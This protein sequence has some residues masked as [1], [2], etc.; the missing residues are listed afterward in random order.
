MTEKLL[1]KKEVA[2]LIGCSVH[3]LRADRRK[4]TG[5]RYVKIDRRIRYKP[6]DVDAYIERRIVETSTGKKR[7]G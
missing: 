3:T 4:N 1:N 7:G 2:V 5:I 6:A